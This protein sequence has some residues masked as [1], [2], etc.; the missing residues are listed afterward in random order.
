VKGKHHLYLTQMKR[1]PTTSS[2][3]KR[4]KGKLT[5]TEPVLTQSL[6]QDLASLHLLS[7]SKTC[8][9]PAETVVAEL[10]EESPATCSVRNEAVIDS[11]SLPRT[12]DA[13]PKKVSEAITKTNTIPPTFVKT[14]YLSS[15]VAVTHAVPA[16]SS[17]PKEAAAM[18][19]SLPPT[20]TSLPK[21][22]PPKKDVSINKNPKPISQVNQHIDSGDVL[23][24]QSG[25]CPICYK[26]VERLQRHLHRTCLAKG[27]TKTEALRF[28]AQ[29]EAR[30]RLWRNSLTVQSNLLQHAVVG[31]DYEPY[32][33]VDYVLKYIQSI[34]GLVCLDVNKML[35]F[36]HLPMEISKSEPDDFFT[37]NTT[38]PPSHLLLAP[39]SEGLGLKPAANKAPLP[40]PV[41]PVAGPSGVLPE[42]RLSGAKRQL[43]DDLDAEEP[44]ALQM[45]FLEES[46]NAMDPVISIVTAAPSQ[47]RDSSS[48]EDIPL[49]SMLKS[50]GT[51]LKLEDC[52]AL[53]MY[54]QHLTET[55]K[56]KQKFYINNLIANVNKI[57]HF[58]D[59]ASEKLDLLGDT[60]QL[61]CFFSKLPKE[62]MASS[63]LNYAKS[64]QRFL[65]YCE[66]T[67]EIALKHPSLM[68][69]MTGIR[70]TLSSLRTEII[71]TSAKRK[72]VDSFS[73]TRKVAKTKENP[74]LQPSASIDLYY[75]SIASKFKLSCN[76]KVPVVS[77]IRDSLFQT[78]IGV[79]F[80]LETL[81]R[82]RD[83]FK[84]QRIVLR[85]AETIASFPR[86]RPT[87]QQL[88]EY[89]E[90]KGW[91][92]K[93][94]T[95]DVLKQWK[96]CD[97]RGATNQRQA[98]LETQWIECIAHQKWPKCIV[99]RANE[100]SMG[101][102][103]FAKE[104]IPKGEVVCDYHGDLI[105]HA[106]GLRRYNAYP[107]SVNHFMMFFELGGTKYCLDGNN[108]CKCHNFSKD[109]TKGRLV[110]HSKANPNLV[111]KPYLLDGT[112]RVLLYAKMDIEL[113]TEL[114]Y[115]YGVAKDRL[116]REDGANEFLTK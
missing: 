94:I 89:L 2:R 9:T 43:F 84:Y 104:P 36:T 107:Q 6:S 88:N 38:Q 32:L 23:S 27:Y 19:E 114:K 65:S 100:P 81:T 72:A 77:Q 41:S 54:K 29:E 116:S 20:T 115:D 33:S 71:A 37:R 24:N 50:V 98:T 55:L 52:P 76:D 42:R 93:R 39:S 85:V 11:Q 96:P 18:A 47:R 83:R 103:V 25:F 79:K 53:S 97:R 109:Q 112:P 34:G 44:V 113:G 15:S 67:P 13:E 86:S 101:Q 95:T 110:N 7:P 87:E 12:K 108:N 58:L 31:P 106:E 26:R 63:K 4:R 82:I 80:D 75:D 102:G 28:L 10:C 68:S 56:P 111:C 45:T 21:E 8:I 78:N 17:F 66:K 62:L 49:A 64:L 3:V 35:N 92:Q 61:R 91:I 99:R 105:S 30:H 59:P 5:G 73:S 90:Q 1:K 14:N 48:S 51:Q 74:T 69:D 57:L 46:A 70:E 60:I 40:R 22:V 16:Q